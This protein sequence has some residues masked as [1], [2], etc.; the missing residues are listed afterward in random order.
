MCASVVNTNKSGASSETQHWPRLEAECGRHCISSTAQVPDLLA[1]VIRAMEAAGYGAADAFA[2]RLALEEAV[3]NAV[4]HGHG[5]DPSKQ[6]RVW[7]AVTQSAVK[8]GVED[9]GAGFVPAAVPDPRLPE[10]RERPCGRGLL[11]IRTYMTWVRFNDRGN[12][13]IMCRY[14]SKEPS[15]RIVD[16]TFR[17]GSGRARGATPPFSTEASPVPRL[18]P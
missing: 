15:D 18:R 7:W 11:L 1:D 6:A 5:H 9:E 8:L 17:R 14:R 12:C 13:I 3:V 10:N 4:K 16:A 2:V